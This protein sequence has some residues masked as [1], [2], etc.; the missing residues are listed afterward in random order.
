MGK[1]IE[2]RKTLNTILNG[3]LK[4]QVVK[5]TVDDEVRKSYT[6]PNDC[7]AHFSITLL[8][9]IDVDTLT[10]AQAKALL[11]DLKRQTISKQEKE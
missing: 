4:D 7:A 5:I 10:G 6:I 2:V 9:N 3:L 1:N 8:K 11:A